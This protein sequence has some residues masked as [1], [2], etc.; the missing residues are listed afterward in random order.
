M[1]EDSKNREVWYGMTQNQLDDI[2]IEICRLGI[3]EKLFVYI[4]ER[5]MTSDDAVQL[6]NAVLCY[7]KG[8]TNRD[9]YCKGIYQFSA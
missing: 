5:E 9:F 7:P 4:A 2:Y 3:N 6:I 1:K 8:H